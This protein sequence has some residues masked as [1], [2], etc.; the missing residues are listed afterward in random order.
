ME[1]FKGFHFIPMQ[2]L[3]ASSAAEQRLLKFTFI[4]IIAAKYQVGK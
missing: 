4:S 2:L 1:A 3:T